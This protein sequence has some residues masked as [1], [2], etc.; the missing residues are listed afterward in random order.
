M[1]ADPLRK[2]YALGIEYFYAGD[3]NSAVNC[4][5]ACLNEDTIE[6]MPD[7]FS[8]YALSLINI[9][10]YDQ[11]VE[12]L[13]NAIRLFPDYTDL[14]YS[15]AIA[16]FILGNT[17]E[18]ETLLHRC[19]EMGETPWEKY[20]SSPGTGSFKAMCSLGV[21]YAR[22]GEVKKA[23]ELFLEAASFP[24]G[25]E[26]A[27]ESIVVAKDALPISLKRLLE[28]NGILNSHSL[29]V[30]AGAYTKK[31]CYQESLRYLASASEQLKKESPRNFSNLTRA[32][33]SLL[34]RFWSQA[35]KSLPEASPFKNL[36]MN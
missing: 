29:S 25:F 24:G 21:I 26:Q 14:V 36:V 16:H 32:I 34:L 4:F 8:F 7:F 15:K 13:E 6:D 20:V 10:K 3:F 28:S 5:E 33:D 19:L 22:K 30:V 1:T 2:N 18:A 35:S 23:V 12:L 9:K 27:I 17:G 11:A 31:D